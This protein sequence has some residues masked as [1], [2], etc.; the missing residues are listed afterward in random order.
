MSVNWSAVASDAVTRFGPMQTRQDS[1][2]VGRLER[3]PKWLNLVPMI[4]QLVWLG[5]RYRSITLPSTVNPAILAGGLVGEGKLE[6]F[7]TMG[8]HALAHTA[9]FQSVINQGPDGMAA[10][11]SAMSVVGLAFPIIAKPDIGWCGFGVRLIRNDA[12]LRAYLTQFPLGER[13]IL[14]RFLPYDGEAGLYYVRR[15]GDAK[16]RLT[17]VLLRHFP[18]VRGDGVRSVAALMAGNPR[19][20]RLGRDGLSEPCCDTNYIPA[21]GETVRLSTI[22]STRVGGL[23]ED[24]TPMITEALTDAIDAIARDMKEFHVGRFDVRYESLDLLLGGAGFSIIEVN[25]AGSEAVHAW[26]PKFTLRQAYAIIFSK[27]R[28]LFEIGDAMRKHGHRPVGLFTLAKL[29]MRQQRLIKR[30]P[31]SN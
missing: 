13:I 30:Y 29:H 15:P 8:A 27:H 2:P 9:A 1:R 26:D 31:L 28:I 19:L 14:Q 24:A 6:Y 17:G 7:E 20:S 11:L 16:G 4:V 3:L 23:Y 10:T 5:I 21:A 18:R 12:D 25:G 22:G